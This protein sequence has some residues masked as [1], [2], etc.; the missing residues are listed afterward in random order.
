VKGLELARRFFRDVAFPAFKEKAPRSLSSMAFGLV[1]PGSECYGFDDEISRDHDWGPRVC[2]WIP[3]Q[4]YREQGERLQRIYDE[5]NE[6]YLGYGPVRRLDTRVRRDG[7]ISTERFYRSYLGTDSPPETIRDWLLLPEEAL[8]LCT[9]GAIFVDPLGGFTGMRRALLAYFPRDLWLKKIASRCS[10]V[11]K[12]GQ[13]NLWRAH[14]RGDRIA[15]LYHK[16]RFAREAAALVFLL[17]RT[18]RPFAKWIF[19]GLRSLGHLG[20]TVHEYLLRLASSDSS[21]A[22]QAGIEGCLGVLID[23]LVNQEL[24]E[25]GGPFLLDYGVQIQR[26]IEDPILREGLDSVD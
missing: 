5:L 9:N 12:H 2:I 6:V 8:S 20:S 18:Y 26:T 25:R 7:V 17:Q 11:G 14:Q 10:A 21:Q 24:A 1:G 22:L 13:Y 16:A 15:F 3:E 4:L 23:E 19:H